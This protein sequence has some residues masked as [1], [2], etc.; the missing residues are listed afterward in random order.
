MIED[1]KT[2]YK[3]PFSCLLRKQEMQPSPRLQNLHR[4]G[5]YQEKTLR[6]TWVSAAAVGR[7]EG[8]RAYDTNV[9]GKMEDKLMHLS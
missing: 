9:N 2:L 1:T 8:R 4:A 5:N 6:I 3:A 7:A